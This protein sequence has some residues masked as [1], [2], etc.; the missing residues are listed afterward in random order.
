MNVQYVHDYQAYLP[1]A[2]SVNCES[3]Y[4]SATQESEIFC[5]SI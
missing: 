2:L 1:Y 4:E 3:K 5:I